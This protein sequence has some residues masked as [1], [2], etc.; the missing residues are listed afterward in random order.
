MKQLLII[1]SVCLLPLVARAQAPEEAASTEGTPPEGSVPVAELAVDEPAASTP[2]MTE[3]VATEVAPTDTAA[4]AAPTDAAAPTSIDVSF[5]ARSGGEAPVDPA[6]PTHAGVPW[7]IE[8]AMQ[9]FAQYELA[10][11]QGSDWFHEIDVPRTWLSTAFRVENAIGRVL[12]EGTRAGGDGSLIG[13]GGD[14][15][16]V[17]FR[18]A[19]LGYRLFD[20]LEIRAGLVPQLTTPALTTLW[21]MRAVRA[22]GIRELE[23][24]QPADLGAS[25]R[26]DFPEHFGFVALAYLSGEGYRGRELNRGKTLEVTAQVRPLAFLPEA[27]PLTLTLAYQNGSTSVASARADRFVAGLAWDDPRWGLGLELAYALGIEDRGD[28]EGL[29]VDAWGRVEPLEHLLLAA[30][31]SHFFRNLTAPANGD[32]IST[33]T[34]SVGTW[35]VEAIR[36]FLAFDVRVAGDR[37]RTELPGFESYALRVVFEGNLGARFEGAL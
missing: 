11:P 10:F 17:R 5:I 6:A 24:M 15:L 26:F 21:Q 18:E 25:I 35:I 8:L 37:A 32:E 23:L 28:R 14:S 7:L 22:I 2:A 9:V 27:Q 36:I 33:F 20:M 3:A 1:V 4:V 13:V 31:F 30:R 29:L 16:V 34:G 12:L 19:W